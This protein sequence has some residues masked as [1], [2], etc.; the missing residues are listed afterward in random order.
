VLTRPVDLLD[1]EVIDVLRT[2]WALEPVDIEYSA[3][4]F[5]SH[6]WRA[7]DD[8]GRRWFVSVDDLAAR[9]RSSDDSLDVAYER[10]D[11]ALS[12]ARA[13]HESGAAFVVAPVR[14]TDG[15][16]L[17]RIG[18][19]YA[20]ALYPFVDGRHRGFGDS[21][22]A[23]ERD[24][25]LRLIGTLHTLP[26]AVSRT[27]QVEDF[28]LAQRAE[29]ANA[30][31]ELRTPW[32]TGPYG[33]RARAWFAVRASR[34]EHLLGEHDRLA[35]QARE[36]PD[37]M[38]LTHG[39]PHPGNLIETTSGW[40]LVDW[41]TALIAP[42]ERDLWLLRGPTQSAFDAY[43]NTAGRDVLVA[44][45]EL[46]RVTW[47]LGDVASFAARFHRGHDD[48]ADARFEWVNMQHRSL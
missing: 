2:G 5:G 19:R 30:L 15:G 28:A 44:M 36:R 22:S 38:V 1:L 6:H 20:A 41:D 35:D 42:P 34:I 23:V 9:R 45:S 11:A 3:V 13:V 17:Q 24:E 48:T 4:G 26:G 16:V 21:L 18:D 29:L 7:T 32:H 14:T 10:L 12:T 37:R 40:M 8:A 39:E 46:Y 25:V 27:A 33:E 31:D 43:I 47:E